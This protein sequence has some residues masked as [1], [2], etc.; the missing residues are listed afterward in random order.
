[1]S[2]ERSYLSLEAFSKMLRTVKDPSQI[3]AS[4][5]AV[6]SKMPTE[7]K[8]IGEG[9]SRLIEFCI[10]TDS[11]DRGQ[12]TVAADGWDV[13]NFMKNPV[14][15][16]AHDHYAPPIGNSRSLSKQGNKWM[17]ICEFTP[18]DVNP[19]GYMIYQLYKN[20]F[21]HACSVGF[22]PIEYSFAEE[23][24]WGVNYLQQELLEYS[25]VPVPAN[26]E[27]LV[28][29]RSKG[30]NTTP[31][32]EWAEMVLDTEKAM[33]GDARHQLEILRS[34]AAPSGRALILDLGVSPMAAEVKTEA[35]PSA[36]KRVDR[37]ECGTEGHH[38]ASESEAKQ[39]GDVEAATT[40]VIRQL[41]SLSSLIKGGK[42]VRPEVKALLRSIIDE[43]APAKKE[44]PVQS[45]PEMNITEEDL[46]KA[47]SGSVA[48]T[49]DAA[50]GK[51]D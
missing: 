40:D 34:F 20:N 37:W 31:L 27:A 30:I 13:S 7:V 26:P 8:A 44:E 18:Q 2:A 50:L 11:V 1:M 10:T 19:F 42:T 15:L 45:T 41:Q 5:L 22:Q 23:R 25:C 36:V 38:H 24:N 39:C 9:D 32:K 48:E 12:D 33:S 28:Q 49:I 21:M 43:I 51:I 17:S 35:A 3:D 16:W 14:T 46:R 6:I 4:R 47:I 29:A